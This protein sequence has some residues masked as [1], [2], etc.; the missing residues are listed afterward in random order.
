MMFAALL[1]T[2]PT[3]SYSTSRTGGTGGVKP[4]EPVDE[5]AAEGIEEQDEKVVLGG[6]EEAERERGRSRGIGQ[7]D[8][9]LGAQ[10]ST[11]SD[12]T[13]VGKTEVL[14]GLDKE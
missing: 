6:D 14:G 8:K 2:L 1:I 11:P 13:V 9:G 12:R 5:K 4:E 7:S 10:S 3:R